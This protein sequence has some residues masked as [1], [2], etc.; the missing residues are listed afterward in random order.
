MQPPAEC[1]KA[2]V[3]SRL[4]CQSL[5]LL[6]GRV[7]GATSFLV[8]MSVAKSRKIHGLKEELCLMC[9]LLTR[10][11][12]QGHGMCSLGG[13]ERSAGVLVPR[14]FLMCQYQLN[15]EEWCWDNRASSV[16]N[17][18]EADESLFWVLAGNG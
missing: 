13:V 11:M 16:E 15:E 1:L 2:P 18:E 17:K 3:W 9:A 8:R 6:P 10:R 14:R 12:R 7:K 4:V 5:C